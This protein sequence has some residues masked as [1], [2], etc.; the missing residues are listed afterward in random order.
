MAVVSLHDVKV[1]RG[2]SVVLDVE[3]LEIADGELLVVL[4]PS[5]AGKSTLLRSIAGLE[6]IET[7]SIWFDGIDI[8]RLETAERGVAMVFQDSALYP[9]LNVRGNV[10]FPLK[11]RR[12]PHDEIAARVEAEARVLEIE[13]LLERRPGELGAGHQQLVQ[14]ARAL[15]RVPEVFLM[16]E[17]LARLDAHL[18]VQMRQEFRLLQQGYGVTTLFVTNDQDEA[19]VLADRV[20]VMNRGVICQVAGPTELYQRPAS[21]FVGG[22]IGGMGFINARLVK[23]SPGHW[24]QFG[25]FRLRAWASALADVSSDEVELGVRPED[26]IADPAG[27]EVIAGRGYFLGSHGLVQVEVAP[28]Q[29]IEMRTPGPPPLPGETVRTRLR[30][31]H[32]FDPRTGRALGRI[33]DGAG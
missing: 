7:G 23:D 8:S 26:V 5:G 18:R 4:G 31:L 6:E 1:I 11:L 14:A 27:V 33:E 29:W 12:M 3:R 21:R 16:D 28:G 13:H 2:S 22:F 15:V 20:A 25:G 32:I 10:G 17:P 19:M 24:V 9:F 30:R